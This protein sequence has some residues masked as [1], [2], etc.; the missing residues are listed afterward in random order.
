[1]VLV[2][3]APGPKDA[4]WSDLYRRRMM[5]HAELQSEEKSELG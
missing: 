2:S 1:M 5:E 3:Y 4:R